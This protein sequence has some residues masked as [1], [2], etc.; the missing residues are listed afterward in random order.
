[1]LTLT[2]DTSTHRG[3]VALGRDGSILAEATWNKDSSHSEKIVTE[4]A[5]LY[6]SCDSQLQDTQ[7]I[8]CGVGPGSFT[9]LRVA[10]SFARTLAHSKD[11]PIVAVEDCWAIALNAPNVTSTISV[12]LDAQKNMFF[13][14]DYRWSGTTLETLHS[15][16]LI[17]AKELEKLYTHENC[18]ITNSGDYFAAKNLQFSKLEPFPSAAKIYEQVFHHP[19]NHKE[20]HWQQLQP[21]YLRASAAEEVLAQKIKAQKSKV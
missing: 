17:D 5:A 7:R 1:M 21:L 3:T 2:L 13:Y 6:A 16:T 8:I 19:H 4:L 18:W 12:V 20:L 9:G 14:G 11:I 10:L 15:A